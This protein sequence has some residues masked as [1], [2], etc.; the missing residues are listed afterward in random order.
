MNARA[1]A[2]PRSARARWLNLALLAAAS[3]AVALTDIWACPFAL[4]TGLP[5]PG[6]GMTRAALALL[7]GE[8]TRAVELHPLSPVLVPLAALLALDALYAY[9]AQRPMRWSQ[10][11]G[12][13]MPFNPDW[14]WAAAAVALIGVWAARFMGAFGGPVS[15]EA[16]GR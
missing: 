3:C 8:L 10:L 13:R 5:C 6:C 4:V 14:L 2:T 7:G 11:V 15:L 1:L 16:W 9:V 12:T